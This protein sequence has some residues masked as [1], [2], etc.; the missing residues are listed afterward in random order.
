MLS[1]K[2]IFFRVRHLSRSRQMKLK[3][4]F[5]WR[6]LAK[7]SACGKSIPPFQKGVRGIVRWKKESPINEPLTR[8]FKILSFKIQK[9]GF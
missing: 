2:F 1:G 9:E 3:V 8:N 7:P 5:Q 6:A 4:L